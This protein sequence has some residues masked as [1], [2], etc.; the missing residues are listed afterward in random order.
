MV[1]SILQ[2]IDWCGPMDSWPKRAPGPAEQ[3]QPQLQMWLLDYVSA[4]GHRGEKDSDGYD[5]WGKCA[6]SYR[7]AI[8]DQS[9]LM[10]D[11]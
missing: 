1:P 4:V 8:E 9:S 2:L 10:E 5:R 3:M 6:S 7:V 11:W